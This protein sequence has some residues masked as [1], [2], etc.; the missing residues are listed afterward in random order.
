VALA[1]EL[2]DPGHVLRLL[3]LGILIALAW[4]ARAG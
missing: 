4:L 2:E 3:G 1:R